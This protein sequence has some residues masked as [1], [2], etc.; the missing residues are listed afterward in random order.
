LRLLAHFERLADSLTFW[1][2]GTS[3]PISTA[4]VAMTTSNSMSVKAILIC[5]FKLIPNVKQVKVCPKARITML[6]DLNGFLVC[7]NSWEKVDKVKLTN[8]IGN[9]R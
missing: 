9:T 4:M 2:A 7:R 1:T 8:T 5:C 3:K 6:Y